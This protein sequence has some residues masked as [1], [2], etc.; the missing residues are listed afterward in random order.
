M[1]D[2]NDIFGPLKEATLTDAEKTRLRNALKLFMSEHPAVAPLFVRLTDRFA[3]RLASFGDALA[4]RHFMNAQFAS[5]ALV[6]VLFVGIGTSF[7]AEGA[8]PGDPLY[9][10]KIYVNEQVRGALAVS[11]ASKAQW[12]VE[13]V[14]RRLAEAETLAAQDRLSE[15]ARTQIELSLN[16]SV[17]EFDENVSK[18]AKSESGPLAAAAVRSDLEASL[19]NHEQALTSLSIER[20]HATP[21]LSPII[22]TVRARTLALREH[23]EDEGEADERPRPVATA[24]RARPA[25]AQEDRPQREGASA[26]LMMAADAGPEAL[27]NAGASATAEARVAI[28]RGEEEYHAGNYMKAFST[29]RAAIKALQGEDVTTT[30]T[31]STTTATTTLEYDKQIDD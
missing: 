8:L 16:E 9:A 6:L 23:A 7:A 19:M 27:Q 5:V 28:D 29:F 22:E 1:M 26:T 20:P 4:S 21:T 14:S 18:L 25:P 17:K 30:A 24:M 2:H 10:V 12:N 13:Q 11:E 31:T 3:D 15:V